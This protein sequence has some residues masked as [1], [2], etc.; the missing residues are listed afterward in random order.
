[1]KTL[2]TIGFKDVEQETEPGVWA[3]STFEKKVFTDIT[4]AYRSS[5][6]YGVI[7]PTIKMNLSFSFI[8]DN[9]ITNNI[10]KLHYVVYKGVYYEISSITPEYPRLKIS[11]GGFY[12]GQKGI[13]Q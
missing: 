3:T 10:D 5:E 12:N 4:R 6:D 1:M 2:L 13:T 9:F 7:N 11:T 8:M